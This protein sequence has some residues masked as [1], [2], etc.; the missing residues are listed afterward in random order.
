[1]IL[2]NRIQIILGDLNTKIGKETIFRSITVNHSL[3]NETNNDGFKLIDLVTVNLQVV[4]TTMFPHK[5]I[6]KGTWRS[7]NG[8][9]TNQIDHILIN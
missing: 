3:Y 4:K 8:K 1:M 6:H 9:H 5:N 7:S 2:S